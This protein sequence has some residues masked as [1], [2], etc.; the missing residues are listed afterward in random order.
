MKSY[1]SNK[2][3]TL[4]VTSFLVVSVVLNG[5]LFSHLIKQEDSI[6][7]QQETINKE[8]EDTIL[9]L[10]KEIKELKNKTDKSTSESEKGSSETELEKQQR[11]KNVANEFVNAYL[12]YDTNNLSERRKKILEISTEDLGNKVAPEVTDPGE[13][14][15][16]DPV[17][18]SQVSDM[19][20]YVAALGDGLN[21]GEILADVKYIVKGSEGETATRAFINLKLLSNANEKIQVI[22]FEYYPIN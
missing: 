12:N 6:K 7:R 22:D 18:T 16:S 15:S 1:K 21:S 9:S 5:V 11:Y 17:F 3:I 20:I 13:A 10:Q 2:K 14:L 4:I 8:K 19:K